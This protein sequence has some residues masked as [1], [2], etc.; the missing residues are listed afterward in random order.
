MRYSIDLQYYYTHIHTTHTH[1]HICMQ[2]SYLLVLLIKPVFVQQHVI[3][4][5]ALTRYGQVTSLYRGGRGVLQG[6]YKGGGYRG[7]IGGLQG[8]GCYH[9]HNSSGSSSANTDDMTER[10]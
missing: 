2:T 7:V 9:D 3:H 4:Q 1:T 6:G 8:G 5:H 10:L